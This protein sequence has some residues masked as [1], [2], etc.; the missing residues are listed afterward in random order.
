MTR[1]ELVSA[2]RH[3][4]CIAIQGRSYRTSSGA[5][6]G[7]C[8]A[9]SARSGQARPET[10]AR[11]SRHWQTD[12]THEQLTA[13]LERLTELGAMRR[14]YEA[15]WRVADWERMAEVSGDLRRNNEAL[16]RAGWR[17]ET[18]RRLRE[19]GPA[20]IAAIYVAMEQIRAAKNLDEFEAVLA[21]VA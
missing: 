18:A 21:E 20:G 16:R 6:K 19:L 12:W 5:H 3:F 17:V 9:L 2:T 7:R 1:V 14:A 13:V 8:I 11:L 10:L 4:A 15:G